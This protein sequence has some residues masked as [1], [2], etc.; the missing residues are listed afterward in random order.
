[1]HSCSTCGSSLCTVASTRG[2]QFANFA[3]HALRWG[4]DGRRVSACAARQSPR[5]RHGGGARRPRR[6]RLR[7]RR[8]RE[9]AKGA[10]ASCVVRC[11]RHYARAPVGTVR[12]RARGSRR[13]PVESRARSGNSKPLRLAAAAFIFH[14]STCFKICAPA[15]SRFTLFP[16]P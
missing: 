16:F 9:A 10:R 4:G 7:T 1:M 5:R 8:E 11:R 14:R 13:V 3:V 15:N 6:R 12:R 2:R